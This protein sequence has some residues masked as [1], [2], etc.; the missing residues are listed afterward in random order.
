MTVKRDSS[1]RPSRAAFTFL[2]LTVVIFFVSLVI[3]IVFP[4]A[5]KRVHRAKATAIEHDLQIFSAAFQKYAGEHGDWPPGDGVPGALPEGMK[6]YLS[7]TDWQHRTPIGGHYTWETVSLHRGT[8]YRAVIVIASTPGN[9]V[10]NDR[11]QLLDLDRR[12]DD[13]NLETGVFQLGH[14]HHPL[15]VLER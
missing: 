4:V 3:A 11:L 9:P 1:P 5:Q 14:R 13:G 6:P 15:R 2:K 12:L 10:T 7:E 8:R